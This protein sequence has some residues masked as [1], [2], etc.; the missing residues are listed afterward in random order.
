MQK[1]DLFL[2]GH[3]GVAKSEPVKTALRAD[4]E[5]KTRRSKR[6]TPYQEA[7]AWFGMRQH[8]N[9][10]GQ[11]V[12]AIEPSMDDDPELDVRPLDQLFRVEPEFPYLEDKTFEEEDSFAYAY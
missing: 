7:T 2:N 3:A 9:C 12:A 11:V 6:Y 8:V 10:H 5:A 1:R 4:D